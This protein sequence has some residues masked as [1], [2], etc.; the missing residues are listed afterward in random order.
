MTLK[1]TPKLSPKI[2][3][4]VYTTYG[5]LESTFR[6][7]R[8]LIGER[9]QVNVEK[10]PEPCGETF[11]ALWRNSQSLVEKLPEPCGETSRALWKNSQ[12][13]VEL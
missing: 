1:L 12:V 9:F 4:P 10:L 7:H 6:A 5:G 13:N 11:R 2:D 3:P 8:W